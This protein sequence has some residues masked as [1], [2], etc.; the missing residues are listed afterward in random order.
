MQA[1]QAKVPD[2]EAELERMTKLFDAKVVST[3]EFTQAKYKLEVLRAEAKGDSTEA[4]RVRLRQAEEELSRATEL[5]KLSLIS[6]SEFDQ[7]A[8]KVES[9]RTVARP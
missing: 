2:A 5:H 6:Q 3:S 7:A 9:L 4:A 8:K 1:A